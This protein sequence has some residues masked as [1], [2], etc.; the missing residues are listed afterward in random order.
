MMLCS[1]CLHV[2]R[3]VLLPPDSEWKRDAHT[4]R[5]D[6]TNT[7][8]SIAL[9]SRWEPEHC[10]STTA[11]DPDAQCTCGCGDCAAWREL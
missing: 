10:Q 9:A 6:A 7:A 11:C 2:Y 4:P 1:T 3:P 8:V 5:K